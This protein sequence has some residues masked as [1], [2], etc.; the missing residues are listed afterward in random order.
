MN[1]VNESAK[2]LADTIVE[3]IQEKKGTNIAILDLSKL[4]NT[5]CQY[6]IICE[7]DSTTQVDAI[8]EGVSDYVRQQLNDR[9]IH[10]EG[11]ENALW[12]LLDYF[13]VVVHVFHKD[14]RDFYNLEGLWA[15]AVRT[16]I[17]NLF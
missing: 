5:I 17:E 13:D 2:Q 1:K 10:V 8:A 3:G 12:I 11:R 15:D 7:G 9:P 6:F 16:N 14:Q 4:D